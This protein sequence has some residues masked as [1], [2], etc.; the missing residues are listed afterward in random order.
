MRPTEPIASIEQYRDLLER[1]NRDWRIEGYVSADGSLAR[2]ALYQ[3]RRV[4]ARLLG[5]QETFN[6]ELVQLVNTLAP[7][8]SSLE[9]VERYR[10][11]LAARERRMETAFDE[12]RAEQQELRTTVAVLRQSQ[13]DLVRR[14]GPSS[15]AV[16][17]AKAEGPPDDVRRGEP[18]GSPDDVR[19]GEPSGS[20]AGAQTSSEALSA[21]Y[22]G[23]EDQFRGA[24]EEIAARQ[25]EYVEIFAGASDVL[26]IGCGRGEFLALL[27]ERGVRARGID[28]NDSMVEVCVQKGL[29][30]SKADAL[31]YLR[32]QPAGSLGGLLAAQ[33]VEHLDPA[34]LTNLLDAAYAALRP[35]AP[36]VLETINPACWFAFFESYV[37]DITHVRP[38]HPDT[39]KFLLQA[40]G[41]GGVEIRYQAPYPEH[42][43]LQRVAAPV[44]GDAAATLNANVEKLNALFFTYLD[45]AA[46]GRRS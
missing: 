44:L 22:V 39:L 15:S 28:V 17:L 9:Q 7:I 10:E 33:V 11:A 1:L 8:L 5:P 42:D 13:H 4:L 16:A 3:V 12:L 37:R 40:S 2:R 35:G 25:R 32:A 31:A 45:Y 23:F 19:R 26:D 29:E 27:K 20:P 46:I 18:S 21:K 34:Y 24:P 43:K 14:G 41:F 36:I 30:A 38:L 6:S